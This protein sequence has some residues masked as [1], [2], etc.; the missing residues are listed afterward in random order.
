MGVIVAV[1][2]LFAALA[3]FLA[4][5]LDPGSEEE[6][7]KALLKESKLQT[8]IVLRE[9]CLKSAVGDDQST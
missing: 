4:E 6:Y 8:N 9:H 2:G 1:I 5:K 3:F 7:L